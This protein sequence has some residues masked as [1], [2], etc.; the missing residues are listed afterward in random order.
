MMEEPA[1]ASQEGP[2]T[3]KLEMMRIIKDTLLD[4][5]ED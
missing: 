4:K 3:V 1:K 2:E 5:K